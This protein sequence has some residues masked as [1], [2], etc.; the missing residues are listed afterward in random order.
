VRTKRDQEGGARQRTWLPLFL[1][2]AV[3]TVSGLAVVL[4]QVTPDREVA[5]SVS[6]NLPPPAG[7]DVGSQAPVRQARDPEPRQRR[8]PATGT[9]VALHVPTLGVH[10]PVLSIT[11]EAGALVP[12][13]DPQ[14]LG[15]WSE[16]ARPGAR[17][18][19]ALITGHTVSSGGGAFDH[20]AT[21]EAG[22]PVA[23]QTRQGLIR[24][25]VSAVTV[26]RK[27]TLAR[28]ASRIFDQSVPGRLV[29][30][31]CDDWN[32]EIYLSN[33][34]VRADP[35]QRVNRGRGAS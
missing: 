4:S 7:F 25:A 29:L 12:P 23:V 5:S 28:H 30:V 19:S 17:F 32:G 8:H 2:G 27:A 14:T 33:A 34:V 20:L 26:Y 6:P 18:G 9:P 31:T 24:Y 13:D 10:V 3:I 16:G 15:W 11:T 21:L 1:V 35:I 22:D